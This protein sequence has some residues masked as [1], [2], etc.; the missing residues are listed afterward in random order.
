MTV[1]SQYLTYSLLSYYA[2]EIPRQQLAQRLR[3]LITCSLESHMPAVYKENHKIFYGN[4]SIY[5][6]LQ[7]SPLHRVIH[8]E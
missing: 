1:L 4:T 8:G 3:V 7:I 2:Y 6:F 5:V